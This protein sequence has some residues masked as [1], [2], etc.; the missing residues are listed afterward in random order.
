MKLRKYKKYNG[1]RNIMKINDGTNWKLKHIKCNE[2]FEIPTKQRQQ[3][4]NKQNPRKLQKNS[5]SKQK[6][7]CQ[8]NQIFEANEA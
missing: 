6:Y 3:Q 8:T 7:M 2:I 4:T 1:F 5:F